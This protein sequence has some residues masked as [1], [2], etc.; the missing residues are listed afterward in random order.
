MASVTLDSIWMHDADD[1]SDFVQARAGSINVVSGS[2]G[3]VRTYAGG[4]QRLIRGPA[5][6]RT[7]TVTLPNIERD[8]LDDV[9]SRRGTVQ[10]IRDGRGRV[11]FGTFFDLQL[12]ETPGLRG[13]ASASFTFR[14]V[15][16][17]IEV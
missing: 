4:R 13:R 12:D 1:Y 16:R 6:P 17:S 5:Q 15:T 14:E 3:E 10:M 8:V 11:V 7:L 9:E 2:D